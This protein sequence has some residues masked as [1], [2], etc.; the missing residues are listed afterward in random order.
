MAS[1]VSDV[2]HRIRLG[3]FLGAS[4]VGDGRDLMGTA[5]GPYSSLDDQIFACIEAAKTWDKDAKLE[6]FQLRVVANDLVLI[7]LKTSRAY[8]LYDEESE[9]PDLRDMQEL[10]PNLTLFPKQDQPGGPGRYLR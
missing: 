4:T 5:S 9:L 10:F 2:G 3:R 1:R 6:E 8:L 7:N